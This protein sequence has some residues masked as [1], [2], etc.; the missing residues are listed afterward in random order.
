[1]GRQS[2]KLTKALWNDIQ[3]AAEGTF[4]V[5]GQLYKFRARHA[6]MIGTV[7]RMEQSYRAAAPIILPITAFVVCCLFGY[8]FNSVGI[9][10]K[11]MLTV[12]MPLCATY[13]LAV[14]AFQYGWFQCFGIM[15]IEDGLNWTFFY[16]LMSFLF[17]LAVD[18]DMFLFA[19]VYEYRHRGYDNDSAVV[20]ALKETGPVITTAGTIMMLSFF[21]LCFTDQFLIQQMSFLYFAGVT[22]DTYIVRPFIAPAA[23]V[24]SERVNYWPGKVPPV[25]KSFQD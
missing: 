16:T 2:Q 18:Y 4:S 3:P 10:F 19:R 9:T 17:A 11:V 21:T 22:V 5:D 13:G 15:K 12:I 8:L 23:L 24:I 14:G 7:M 6:S 20:M 1:M 25:T